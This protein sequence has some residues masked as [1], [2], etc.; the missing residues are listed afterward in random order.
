MQILLSKEKLPRDSDYFQCKTAINYIPL[1]FYIFVFCNVYDAI[2][3]TV[4]W[5]L[6]RLKPVDLFFKDIMFPERPLRT[7][8]HLIWIVSEVNIMN[9]ETER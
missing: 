8:I 9:Y 5:K 3:N 6:Y 7:R 4:I 1:K 2:N